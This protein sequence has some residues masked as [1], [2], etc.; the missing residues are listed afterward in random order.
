MTTSTCSR[1]RSIKTFAEKALDMFMKAPQ[2][3]VRGAR[4]PSDMSARASTSKSWAHLSE[5]PVIRRS[6][7]HKVI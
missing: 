7:A 5:F 4:I 2:V 6:S 3:S 1:S